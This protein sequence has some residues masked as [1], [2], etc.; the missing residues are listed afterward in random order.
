VRVLVI[1]DCHGGRALGLMSSLVR[2]FFF[3]G[4]IYSWACGSRTIPTLDSLAGSIAPGATVA[5]VFSYGEL[6]VRMHCEKWCLANSEPCADGNRV[7]K[8]REEEPCA[9]QRCSATAASLAAAMVQSV[10]NSVSCLRCARVIP[11]VLAVPPA[12]DEGSNPKVSP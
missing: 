7:D 8:V 6:D 12:S 1:G 3:G 11:I 2:S 5:V 10:R 4:T 9:E